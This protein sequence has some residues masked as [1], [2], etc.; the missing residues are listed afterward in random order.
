MSQGQTT[1]TGA[2]SDG[3]Q[4]KETVRLSIVDRVVIPLVTA[5]LAFLA[6]D[7]ST[8]GAAEN[9]REQ[10]EEQRRKDD[11]DRRYDIYVAMLP[12]R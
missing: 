9:Q 7:I 1:G 2:S 10:I 8:S 12:L 11:R 4:S 6:A 3:A 5:G